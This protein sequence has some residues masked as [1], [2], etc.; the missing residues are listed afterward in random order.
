MSSSNG[1]KLSLSN[2]KLDTDSLW[3]PVCSTTYKSYLS[4]SFIDLKTPKL[5]GITTLKVH[6]VTIA[7]Q[8][9]V[10][11]LN[12]KVVHNASLSYQCCEFKQPLLIYKGVSKS[13][14]TALI[15]KYMLT[16]IN[17]H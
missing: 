15:T 3:P 11:K 7:L 10:K 16:T 13:F 1:H 9:I 8:T 4:K 2:Q 17:T 12:H 14:Q 6:T 5:H